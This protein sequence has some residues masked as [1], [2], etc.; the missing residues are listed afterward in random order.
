MIDRRNF[1]ASIAALGGLSASGI[2]Q[3]LASAATNTVAQIKFAEA[4]PFSRATVVEKAKALAAT[5]FQSPEKISQDWID[6]TYDQYRGINF[7]PESALW[8]D[9]DDAFNVEFFA[10]GLYFP[11]PISVSV[12]ED[13]QSKRVLFSK[14]VFKL[15]EVV[16]DLPVDEKLGYSGF[17]IRTAI[18]D[19]KR[20]DEFVV[21]QGASYFRAVGKGHNYG[22]SARGLALNTAEA[23]G[24]EFPEFREFWV[25]RGDKDSKTVT[26]HALMDSP[27]VTG[28]YSFVI[29]PGEDTVMDVRANIFPR[30]DLDHVGIAAETSMFLFDETNRTRFDDFRP[31]VHDNDG[32]L[33]QNGAGETLWRALANPLSLQVSSFVDTNPKGFGLL[34]RPRAFEDYADLEANYHNRPGL[35][36]VPGED[37]GKGSVTLVEIPADREIYDNIVAYWRPD[38]PIK[39]GTEHAFTYKLYWC[40]DEPVQTNLLKVINTRMGKRFAGGRIVTIDFAPGDALP[41]DLSTITLHTSANGADVSKGILQRNPKTGGVRLAFNFD[42]AERTSIELRAQLRMDGKNISEVWL[43]RWTV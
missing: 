21:F 10:P 32:L 12:V 29:E 9:S 16:P 42:P 4:A 19:P 36:V 14:D 8:R 24:E 37:W 1:I 23:Q 5:D 11:S 41:D 2:G 18:N 22:L 3:A 34:Q 35:W 39:A 17:R 25:E 7:N 13:N 43:Y 31:A 27:S 20:K 28:A 38:A 15:A 33:V 30:T 6:L 26:V 40:G